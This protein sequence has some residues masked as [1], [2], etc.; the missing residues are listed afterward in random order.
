MELG[1]RLKEYRARAGMTQDELAEILFVSRQTI[2]S[3]ENDKSY[4][5]I[6][7]LLML[8]DVFGV[9]LDTLVKGDIEIMKEK[10]DGE[11]IRSFRRDSNIF[12]VLLVAVAV[13][14]IPLSR[15][16]GIWGI[17][18]WVLL[19]AA[20]MF[21]AVKLEKVKKQQDIRTYKEIVAFT[22]GEKLDGIEKAREEG[23]RNYQKGI[24]VLVCAAAGLLVTWIISLIIR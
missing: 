6:H 16:A 3:W 8:G 19:F 24:A 23:K 1:K 17:G 11:T 12:A 20:A 7:S 9:S 13:S 22:N 2:S 18:A 5:D 4:P 21:Y 15:W 10:I 14:L